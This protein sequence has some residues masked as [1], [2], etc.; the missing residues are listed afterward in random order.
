MMKKEVETKNKGED[1]IFTFEEQY[2][3]EPISKNICSSIDDFYNLMH[4][5]RKSWANRKYHLK[6]E[7]AGYNIYDKNE[8]LQ[9]WI[10]IKEKHKSLWFILFYGGILYG[11]AYKDF[12][13]PMQVFDFDEDLWVYSKLKITDILKGESFEKQR[14]IIKNWINDNIKKIFGGDPQSMMEG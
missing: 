14:E 12:K 6:W 2:E 8:D 7:E 9:A 4:L 1:Y 5:I 13:G 10:G 11:N 3:D